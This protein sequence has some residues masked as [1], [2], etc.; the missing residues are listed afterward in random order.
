[1]FRRKRQPVWAKVAVIISMW[2]LG[3]IIL[4]TIDS[5]VAVLIGFIGLIPVIIGIWAI[6]VNEEL[7]DERT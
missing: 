3:I 6:V 7:Q 5:D 4:T 2:F 1:M